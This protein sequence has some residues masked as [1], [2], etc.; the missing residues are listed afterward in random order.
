[1][2]DAFS[3]TIPIWAAVLNR[4]VQILR[5][6]MT[7]D[8]PQRNNISKTKTEYDDAIWDTTLFTPSTCVTKEEH[9]KINALLDDRVQTLI[10]SGVILD[11]DWLIHNFDRPLRPYWITNDKTYSSKD[12]ECSFNMPE[13]SS[14][15]I[16]IV[17]ISC[18]RMNSNSSM[19][20]SMQN[21]KM[22]CKDLIERMSTN[23][24]KNEKREDLDWYYSPGAA[25]DDESWSHGLTPRLFWSNFDSILKYDTSQAPF[26]YN[27]E[28]LIKKTESFILKIVQE[29]KQKDEEWNSLNENNEVDFDQNQKKQ[30]Q[31]DLI[32]KLFIKSHER[33]SSD[34]PPVLSRNFRNMNLKSS[35]DEEDISCYYSN[36]GSTKLAI[37]SRRSG[38]PPQC[39]IHFDAVLNVTMNEYSQIY[40]MNDHG[41]FYLQI[42]VCEGKRDRTELENWMAVAMVFIIGHLNEGRKVLVHCAQGKD[43][44]VA[45]VMTAIALFFQLNKA[46]LPSISS[47]AMDLENTQQSSFISFIM[48]SHFNKLS[49]DYMQSFISEIDEN[50]A[51]QKIDSKE[52][53]NSNIY[54]KSGISQLMVEAL[55]GRKGR[56]LL[57]SWISKVEGDNAT[58][59]VPNPTKKTLRL[60]L[61]FIQSFREKA[62]PSR[63]TMQKINRF[64]MSSTYEN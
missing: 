15:Y 11:P 3:R 30:I 44:S 25:D 19:P 35:K 48:V 33:M 45:V 14:R 50:R 46:E 43:R 1:M 40:E 20:H 62:S 49:L 22:E 13:Y 60:A 52:G 39:W 64:L 59:T 17:C 37:G 24:D 9:D 18:S 36:I 21:Q 41:K 51:Y 2:P 28:G 32:G 63:N 6:N 38:R 31:N 26:E 4:T 55:K 42:P 54:R 10:Q 8:H 53:C 29:A 5:R 12:S 61:H 58:T 34:T 47:N 16:S 57:L 27:E 7:H 23:F 56:N